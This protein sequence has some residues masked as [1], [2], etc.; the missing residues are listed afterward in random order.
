MLRSIYAHAGNSKRSQSIQVLCDV[1]LQ[2]HNTCLLKLRIS[3]HSWQCQC[4]SVMHHSLARCVE[5]SMAK[6]VSS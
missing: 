6:C 4:G 1:R 2:D 5:A 3:C